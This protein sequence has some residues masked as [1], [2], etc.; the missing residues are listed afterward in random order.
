MMSQKVWTNIP[1]DVH[2][3]IRRTRR[4]LRVMAWRL[5]DREYMSDEDTCW[6]L[7]MHV[8]N[9]ADHLDALMAEYEL[10]S[11]FLPPLNYE[12]TEPERIERLL[13]RTRRR[14]K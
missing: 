4:F 8:D 3:V 5:S 6:I 12:E 11:E 9:E 7:A 2:E 10:P 1:Q 14:Q 13:L